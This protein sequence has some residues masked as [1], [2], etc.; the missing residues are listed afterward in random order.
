MNTVTRELLEIADSLGFTF[1]G[2]DGGGHI[3]L[4]LPDGR[5]T[6]IAATPSEY[7]GRKNAIA[8]LERLSGRTMPRA[9]HRRSR[10]AFRPSGFSVEGSKSDPAIGA[11]IAQLNATHQAQRDEWAALCANPSHANACRARALLSE[12]ADTED[13]L[14]QLHQPVERIV[15]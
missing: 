12:I 3:V 9:N 5:R 2:Y 6:S 11:R 15:A 4:T 1:E 7:R 14:A 10:K 13:K 8:T